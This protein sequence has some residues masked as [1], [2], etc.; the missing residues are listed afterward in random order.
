MNVYVLVPRY[1]KW[2]LCKRKKDVEI[3]ANVLCVQTSDSFRSLCDQDD[4]DGGDGFIRSVTNF[5]SLSCSFSP[6]D[7]TIFCSLGVFEHFVRRND[8]GQYVTPPRVSCGFVSIWD[9]ESYQENGYNDEDLEGVACMF[10]Y[11]P[12]PYPAFSSCG[13]FICSVMNGYQGNLSLIG[14]YNEDEFKQFDTVDLTCRGGNL[15]GKTS[16]CLIGDKHALTVTDTIV[17]DGNFLKCELTVWKIVSR[18]LSLKHY[19][20]RTMYG[21]MSELLDSEVNFQFRELLITECLFSPDLRYIGML[22]SS[23]CPLFILIGIEEKTANI[24]INL[25]SLI[26]AT[27][28]P[29]ATFPSFCFHP[30]FRNRFIAFSCKSKC[31]LADIYNPESYRCIVSL[32]DDKYSDQVTPINHVTYSKNGEYFSVSTGSSTGSTVCV[33]S[34]KRM[35][36]LLYRL[37]PDLSSNMPVNSSLTRANCSNFSPTSEELVV[38]YGDGAIRVWQ[39]PRRLNLKELCRTRCLCLYER[40]FLEQDSRIPKQLKNYLFFVPEF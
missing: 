36:T 18:D 21:I 13:N 32:V 17:T 4:E 28:D 20:T 34:T 7:S 40:H 3:P 15:S 22:L 12:V 35:Y 14:Y 25:R 23:T 2:R 19:W 16:C 38:A 5:T 8:Q 37:T 26:E 33:Y 39:L 31:Y 9:I 1:K 10:T 30:I 27:R 6:S 11:S 29:N 24:F